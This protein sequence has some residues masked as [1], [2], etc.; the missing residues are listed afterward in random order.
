MEIK[1]YIKEGHLFIEN[2]FLTEKIKLDAIDNI[3]IY[4]HGERYENRIC[5]YLLEPIIYENQKKTFWSKLLFYSFLLFNKERLIIEERYHNKDLSNILNK[6][7]DNLKE[8]IIPN[9]E[10]SMFWKTRDNGYEI[11]MVKLVYSKKGLGLVNVLKKY[12]KMIN[13]NEL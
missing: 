3:L 8:I 10:G 9:L 12:R 11:P 13:E 1:A 4:H 5:F 7:K 6:L 2:F